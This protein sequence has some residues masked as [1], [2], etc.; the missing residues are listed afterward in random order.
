MPSRGSWLASFRVRSFRF[1]WP[2][3]LATGLAFEMETLILGWYVL[4]ETESVLLLTLWGS[5][6]YLGTL[7]SPMFGVAGDRIGHRN[8]LCLMRAT[9]TVLAATLMVLALTGTLRPLYVFA[10]TLVSGLVRPSDNA[11]RNSLIGETIPGHQLMAAM[12]VART[13]NDFARIAGAL[14]G[15]GLVATLGMGPAYLGITCFYAISLLLTLQVGGGRP[16][17]SEASARASPWRDLRDGVIYVWSTPHLRA[18][19]CLALLVNI[20]AYPLTSGVL[21]YVARDVYEV[22]QTGLGY[23]VASFATGAVAG[24]I[25]LGIKGGL[26][27]PARMMVVFSLVWH[28]ALLV[29]AHQQSLA[30]G[31]VLLAVAGCMQSLCMVP[32][33]VMLLRS[34][35]PRFRGRLM[36]VR[37]MAVYGMPIGLLA[38]GPLIESVGLVA[39]ATAYGV[40]GILVT[41]LITLWWRAHLW[42]PEAPANA[43]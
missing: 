38:A 37:M 11:M 32:M 2:A 27:R 21:P 12:S 16:G 3:D 8:L 35:D 36:G 7:I 23:L 4:V 9:Y 30:G 39:M 14:A 31:I 33:S 17:A 19:M 5:L 15:A 34:S 22:G 6:Q 10:V 20:T 43:R 1:Q 26:I 40:A 41:L 18:T 24:S 29:F 25:V 28:A 42:H 13:T